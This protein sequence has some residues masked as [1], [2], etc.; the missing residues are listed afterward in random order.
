M[1][2]ATI[3]D[4]NDPY[5][6]AQIGAYTTRSLAEAAIIIAT[7]RSN[8]DDAL[9]TVT[10]WDEVLNFYETGDVSYQAVIFEVELGAE[11][12]Q[13]DPSMPGMR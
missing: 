1:F 5:G 9:F 2:I 6:D 11:M 7:N 4:R 3:L 8:Q 12:K 10:T 13:F